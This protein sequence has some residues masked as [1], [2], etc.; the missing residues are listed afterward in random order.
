MKLFEKPWLEILEIRASD[1][2]TLSNTEG[3]PDEVVEG[4]GGVLDGD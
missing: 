2:V 4:E 3:Y 1:I